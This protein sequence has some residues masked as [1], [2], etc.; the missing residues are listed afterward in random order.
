M[1]KIATVMQELAAHPGIEGC[2]LVEA[3]TGMVWHY[4]GT[5][6]DIERIGEATIEF[7]RVEKRLSAQLQTLGQL[8]SVAYSFSKRVVALFPCSEVLDLVLICVAVKGTISWEAWGEKVV[9][10]QRVLTKSDMD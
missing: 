3:S 1:L 9:L 2:V 4:S 10:L 7:W 6:Q 5:C 8:R